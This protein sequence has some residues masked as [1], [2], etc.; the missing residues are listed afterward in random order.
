LY[1]CGTLQRIV[2]GPVFLASR[3]HRM[4]CEKIHK[5]VAASARGLRV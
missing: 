5:R 3:T 2:C 1:H 4:A